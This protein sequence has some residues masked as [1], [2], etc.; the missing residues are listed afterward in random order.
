MKCTRK[1]KAAFFVYLYLTVVGLFLISLLGYGIYDRL[2]RASAFDRSGITVTATYVGGRVLKASSRPERP[3]TFRYFGQV[4]FLVDG[5][6]ITAEAPVSLEFHRKVEPGDEI[7]I[8]YLSGEPMTVQIDPIHETREFGM[9]WLIVLFLAGC[10]V[11]WLVRKRLPKRTAAQPRPKV[12][13]LKLKQPLPGWLKVLSVILTL[14]ALASLF[15]IS[16]K[17]RY[18]VEAATYQ[19]IGWLSLPLAMIAMFLPPALIVLSNVVLLRVVASRMA[20]D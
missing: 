9:I 8:R 13:R 17:I 11:Y 5:R 12:I 16:I 19:T 4:Q 2:T 1:N 7:Q 14:L 20:K 3:P 18:A 10:L 15:T 6:T